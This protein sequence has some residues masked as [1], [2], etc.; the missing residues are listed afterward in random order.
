MLI[1]LYFEQHFFGPSI[2]TIENKTLLVI[3]NSSL[4]TTH[5]GLKRLGHAILGFANY[6]NYVL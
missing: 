4:G 2:F 6:A 1:L 3:P 5:T